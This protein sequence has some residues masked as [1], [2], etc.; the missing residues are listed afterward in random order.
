MHLRRVQLCRRPPTMT[1]VSFL[2]RGARIRRRATLT[3][4]PSATTAV[5]RL[6]EEGLDCD[7]ACLSGDLDGDGIC[8]GDE[9]AGCTHVDACNFTPGATEDDGSCFFLVVAWPDT[10]GDGYGDARTGR[11]TVLRGAAC[12][13]GHHS[14]RLQR[15]ERHFYPGAPCLPHL[16]ATSIAMASSRPPSLRLVRV[17]SIKMA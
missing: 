10:D 6:P 13:M 9:F 8:D 16:A 14:G 1:P 15:C 3:C 5:R 11:P 12:R 17:T 2:L 4:S 7:G